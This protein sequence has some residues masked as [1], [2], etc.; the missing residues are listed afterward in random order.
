MSR[1]SLFSVLA[2]VLCLFVVA[3]SA[4]AQT[5][6]KIRGKVTDQ[7][8]GEPLIGANVAVEGTT[9]GAAANLDGTY[10]ILTVPPGRYVLRASFI[11]YQTITVS[12]VKVNIGLTTELDFR[13]PSEAIVVPTVEIVAEAPLVNKS[14]TNTVATIR[15]EDIELLPLRG[16]AAF[17]GLSAGIV[18]Q[19]GDFFVRGGRAE[20]TA[21]YMD[22]VLV[23]NPINGRLTLNIINNAIE[24]VQTQI[25]GMTAEYGN[26]MSGIVNTTSKIGGPR[27]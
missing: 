25:G 18:R 2:I 3:T 8:T 10:I 5:T 7:E 14:A 9:L 11:G 19:G 4:W 23:N 17:V 15:A 20:E 1:S 26:A 21:F 16:V 13:L 24:E 27:Y 6:G 12:N 22:G